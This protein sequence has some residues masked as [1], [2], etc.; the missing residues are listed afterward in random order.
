LAGS[1]DDI[2]EREQATTAVDAGGLVVFAVYRLDVRWGLGVEENGVERDDGGEVKAVESQH[3]VFSGVV[4]VV[5]TPG[6]R[7]DEVA[8]VHVAGVAVD[9]GPHAFT[10]EDETDGAGGVAVVGGGLVGA[11]VL[12]GAPEGVG[13]VGFATEAGVG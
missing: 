9:G 7:E 10:F 2:V 12:D 1:D 11:K 3:G 13:G 8:G 6:W 5:P 4:V